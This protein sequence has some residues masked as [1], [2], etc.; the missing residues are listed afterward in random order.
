MEKIICK[1][2]HLL[3]EMP[4]RT[5]IFLTNAFLLSPIWA[6]TRSN[7]GVAVGHLPPPILRYPKVSFTD[8]HQELP[9]IG[10]GYIVPKEYYDKYPLVFSHYHLDRIIGRIGMNEKQRKAI[11]NRRIT[12]SARAVRQLS[13]SWYS[14]DV[15]RE[16][17]YLQQ[18]IITSKIPSSPNLLN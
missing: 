2:F 3:Q 11:T 16:G 9:S 10:N 1:I 6:L 14:S 4:A 13:D 7:P 12:D 8:S 17:D 18:Q 15:S 5:S